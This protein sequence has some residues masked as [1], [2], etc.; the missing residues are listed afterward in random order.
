MESPHAIEAEGEGVSFRNLFGVVLNRAPL[1]LAIAAAVFTVIMIVAATRTPLY[2]ATGSLTIEPRRENMALA[3]ST[4]TGTPV[5]LAATDTQVEILRSPALA[6]AVVRK[7]KLFEDPEFAPRRAPTGAPSPALIARVTDRVSLRARIRRVGLTSIAQVGFISASPAKAQTIANAFIETYLQRQIVAKLTSLGQ[8]GSE[9]NGALDR[10]RQDASDSQAALQRYRNDHNL[11]TTQ[12]ATVAEVEVS[13]LDQQVAAARADQAEKD[14]RLGAALQQVSQGSGGADVGAALASDT[15]KELRKQEAVASTRLAQ[16]NA[17]FRPEYPEV[18]S[19]QAEVND[20]R[21]QIQAE[22]NRIM[23]SL[24]ADAVAA[25]RREGSLVGSRG[26]AAG[27]LSSINQAQVGLVSL[28]QRADASK[29]I[30]EAYLNRANQVQVE[31]SSQQADAT[32]SATAMLPTR[33]SS[34]NLP[35]VGFLAAVLALLAGAASI[36]VAEVWERKMRSRRDV[37]R[38]LGVPFAGILPQFRSAVPRTR[39]L[40]RKGARPAEHLVSFPHT[41]FAEAFRNV[42]A[43]LLITERTGPSRIIALTSALPGEGKSMSSL[44]LA[45]TLALAGA[46]V[47]LVDCDTRHKGASRL[48][49]GSG[50]GFVNVVKGESSLEMALIPDTSTSLA[51]LPAGIGIAPHDLFGLPAVDSLLKT[52]AEH[53]DHVILDTQPVLGV[54]DARIIAAK[55]DQV[56]FVAKWNSTAAAAAQAAVDM[57]RDCGANVVG[58]VLSQVNVKHQSRY[59]FGDSSDYY[60]YFHDYYLPAN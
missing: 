47:V 9:L 39:R 6:E 45:R 11:L 8:A 10:L 56:L 5:D 41:G 37:E 23:S 16:L 48:V 14:A 29:L 30:Y 18:K 24:R 49:G 50:P 35:L 22:I 58:A 51:I 38:N 36:V 44:C 13:N 17:R 1:A 32:V 46:R 12:G 43:Y 3:P 53:Y 28:Q 52:L 54:A 55:A 21:A 20:L 25:S 57:L 34:P 40:G 4:E 19:T 27:G 2:E 42:R 33:P 26:Q 60:S 15:I 59:G 7:L 31:A